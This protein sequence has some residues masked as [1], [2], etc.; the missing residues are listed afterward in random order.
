MRATLN[1]LSSAALG[2]KVQEN[3]RTHTEQGKD[4]TPPRPAKER[5]FP[6]LA[7]SGWCP[8]TG[9]KDTPT[10]PPRGVDYR[11]A[12]EPAAVCARTTCREN[13]ESKIRVKFKIRENDFHSRDLQ[14]GAH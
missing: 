12:N 8:R 5:W 10:T 13:G 1:S 9:V 7:G 4:K 11:S 14:I 6:R 3:T 2:N